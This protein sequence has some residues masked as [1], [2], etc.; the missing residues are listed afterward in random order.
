MITSD[1]KQKIIKDLQK[2]KSDVGSSAV[3]VGILTKRIEEITEHLKTNKKDHM[4]RRGLL[5][6][7]GKR[8]RHLAYI[9]KKD[10]AEYL[11][12]IKKLGLR[13]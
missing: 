3:Q 5:Q 9:A 11:A 6:M 8:K 10:S 1:N 12:L 13:R 7:V 2:S 4:A